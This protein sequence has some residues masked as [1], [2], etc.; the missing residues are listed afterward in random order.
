MRPTY[1]T[2]TTSIALALAMTVLGSAAPHAALAPNYQ[3]LAELRA[4]LNDPGVIAAF[5]IDALTSLTYVGP[6]QYQAASDRCQ[7]AVRIVG[8][9]MPAGMVGARQFSVSPGRIACRKQP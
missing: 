2:R 3:R 5:G 6:D 9:P 4:I 7:L 1:L 8:R